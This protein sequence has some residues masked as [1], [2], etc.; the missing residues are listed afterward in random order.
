MFY[1]EYTVLCVCDSVTVKQAITHFT[2]D[3][4]FLSRQL[5]AILIGLSLWLFATV[6][7]SKPFSHNKKVLYKIK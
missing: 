3:V 5:D 6:L 4:Q 1:F 7:S 2:R